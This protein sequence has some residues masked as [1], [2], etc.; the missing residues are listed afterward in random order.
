M[1]AKKKSEAVEVVDVQA[2]NFTTLSVTVIGNAPY[3][4]NKWPHGDFET[5]RE[6][7]ATGTTAKQRAKSEGRKGKDFRKQYEGTLHLSSEGWHGIP[8]TAFLQALVRAGSD[9]KPVLEMSQLKRCL[10]IIPDGFAD[11]GYPLVRVLDREPEY[12]ER[13]TRLKDGSAN[14]TA[15]ARLAPG[16]RVDL[17]ISYDADKYTHRTVVNLLVR[18][19]IGVGVGAGRPASKTSCG[20]GWGTWDVEAHAGEMPVAAE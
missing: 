8:A 17:Q 15:A 10:R 7:M 5:M 4:Y 3:Y 16:W 2:P 13:P 6:N 20:M 11:D 1:A 14:I 18:A 12:S 9:V 19:G